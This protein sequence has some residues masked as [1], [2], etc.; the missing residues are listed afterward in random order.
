M[1]ATRRRGG[2]A[3]ASE[4]AGRPN[5]AQ[6]RRG[7]RPDGA[8]HRHAHRPAVWVGVRGRYGFTTGQAT[9]PDV[10]HV[11]RPWIDGAIG[12]ICERIQ[13]KSAQSRII[14]MG[15]FP[16]GQKADD[17][18]RAKIARLNGLLS[19]LAKEKG[20]TFLDLGRQMLQADGSMSREIMGDFCHPTE[21][22]YAIWAEA[23]KG[24]IKDH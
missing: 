19:A 6:G 1:G 11:I 10:V 13:A 14:L 15:V 4:R 8:P 5:A 3:R 2:S 21:K 20:L 18:Y 7:T 12:A 23:L 22:G 24:V 16:R 17:P 9:G